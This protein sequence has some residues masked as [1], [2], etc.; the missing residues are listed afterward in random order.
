MLAA[1][2]AR[3]VE[4]V[5]DAAARVNVAEGLRVVVGTN[6]PG[7]LLAAAVAADVDLPSDDPETDRFAMGIAGEEGALRLLTFTLVI[8]GRPLDTA[9]DKVGMADA[10]AEGDC[11]RGSLDV[12]MVWDV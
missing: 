7:F 2:G 1:L 11:R 3:R 9:V 5:S 8:R 12:T 4:V 6:P 10:L